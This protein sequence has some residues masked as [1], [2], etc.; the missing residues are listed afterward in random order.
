MKYKILKGTETFGKLHELNSKMKKCEA[1]ASSLAIELGGSKD[2]KRL[3]RGL[4]CIA[5]GLAGIE[6]KTK[7]EGWRYASKNH[8]G[9]Y[10][11]RRIK[12]NKEVLDRIENLPVL[13]YNDLNEIVSF[14][15]QASG[16]RWFNCPG[17]DW[18]DEYILLHIDNDCYFTP[19][20]DMVE[21]LESEYIKLKQEA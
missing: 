1:A 18:R 10:Y 19:N 9:F 17:V 15:Q 2:G 4:D 14:D 3:S 8:Y 12:Q 7:L 16:M 5:G 13:T 21:I 20:A 6:M 11:P